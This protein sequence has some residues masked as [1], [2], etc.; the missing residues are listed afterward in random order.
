[1]SGTN[2][3]TEPLVEGRTSTLSWPLVTIGLVA[4]VATAVFYELLRAARPGE[5]EFVVLLIGLVG[6]I[7][8]YLGLH[9]VVLRGAE[10]TTY[11]FFGLSQRRLYLNQVEAWTLVENQNPELRGARKLRIMFHDGTFFELDG[12]GRNVGVLIRRLDKA[13]I[14]YRERP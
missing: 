11:R 13:Q 12:S 3:S 2:P 14:P 10:L 8:L 1:M 9:G 6:L 5:A 4:V 7:P